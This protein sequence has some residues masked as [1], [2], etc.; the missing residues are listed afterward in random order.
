LITIEA[1]ERHE[2]KFTIPAEGGEFKALYGCGALVQAADV[3]SHDSLKSALVNL[4]VEG[5]TFAES[6]FISELPCPFWSRD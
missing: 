5:S 1:D 4:L 6:E 3:A 2:G